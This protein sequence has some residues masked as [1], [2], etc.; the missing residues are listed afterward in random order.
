MARIDSSG[1]HVSGSNRMVLDYSSSDT[2]T[3]TSLREEYYRDDYGTAVN[4]TRQDSNG[5]NLTID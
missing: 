4:G 2:L 5:Q 1:N 3:Q